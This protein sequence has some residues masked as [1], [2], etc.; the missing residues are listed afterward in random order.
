MSL[1]EKLETMEKE[2]STPKFVYLFISFLIWLSERWWQREREK[3]I[4]KEGERSSICSFTSYM[5]TSETRLCQSQEPR[6]LSRS[7][8]WMVRAQTF[9]PPS[10]TSWVHQ[11]E[12]TLKS[13][14]GLDSSTPVWDVGVPCDVLI[15]CATTPV[16]G[17]KILNARFVTLHFISAQ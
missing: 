15:R 1:W 11:Q 2:L 17:R 6:N 9:E 7:P 5:P 10:V 12:T 4:E 13:E 8:T 16:P 3:Q 14:A